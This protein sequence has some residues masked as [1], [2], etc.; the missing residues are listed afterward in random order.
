MKALELIEKYFPSP[1]RSLPGLVISYANLYGLENENFEFLRLLILHRVGT[2]PETTQGL[3]G[4]KAV[5]NVL[6]HKDADSGVGIF[7]FNTR[8]SP[9]VFFNEAG[10][11]PQS[12]LAHEAVKSVIRQ[13]ANAP[14]FTDRIK[15]FLEDLTADSAPNVAVS[16]ANAFLASAEEDAFESTRDPIRRFL[17]CKIGDPRWIVDEPRWHGVSAAAKKIFGL[18]LNTEDLDFFFDVVEK[19]T[20]DP[21]FKYRRAF[22]EAYL[23]SIDLCRACLGRTAKNLFKDH[24]YIK[25]RE[26]SLAWVTGGF[27]PDHSLFLIKIKDF[28]ILES[29]TGRACY[30][31][32]LEEAPISLEAT[33]YRYDRVLIRDLATAWFPHIGSDYYRWQSQIECWLHEEAKVQPSKSYRI[34]RTR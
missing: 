19:T 9:M 3:R 28:I 20:S 15:I 2:A 12:P 5:K 25:E 4:L 27:A 17:L 22:W 8:T 6:F 13:I 31:Y 10:I 26:Q 24:P 1:R 32:L 33:E 23:P 21:K 29:S 16:I 7:L 18:W 30:I 11:P 14:D 34:G